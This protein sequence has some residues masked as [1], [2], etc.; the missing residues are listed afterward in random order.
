MTGSTWNAKIAP[1]SGSNG[2]KRNSMPAR[3]ESMTACTPVEAAVS[4]VRPHGT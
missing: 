4:A 2:P 3:E 1:F